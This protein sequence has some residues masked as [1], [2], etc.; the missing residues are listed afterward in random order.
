[1]EKQ[2]SRRRFIKTSCLTCAGIGLLGSVSLESCKTVS[3]VPEAEANGMPGVLKST[4]SKSDGV[5]LNDKRLPDK[6]LI[7]KNSEDKYVAVS[8]KCT[9]AGVPVVKKGNLLVCNAHGSQF[10]L[11][12]SVKKGPA[13][14]PL[15]QYKVTEN[16][17]FLQVSVG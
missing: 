3:S 12:G 9:H 4:L 6:V 17:E 14:A 2:K 1:M 13:K 15:K 8:V 7:F 11:D 5:V 10:G 16:G